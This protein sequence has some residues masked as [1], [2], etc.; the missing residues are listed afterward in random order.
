MEPRHD[1]F[2]QMMIANLKGA[3]EPE[4]FERDDGYINLGIGHQLYFAPFE[5]WS[6][7]ERQ[8]SDFVQGRVLDIGCGAGR[9]ALHFQA[10]GHD[11][12]ATD[13]S[14]LAIQ[15]CKERG[16]KDARIISVTKLSRQIG[17]F[18]TISLWGSF[19]MVGN[20]KRARW[21]LRRFRGMASGQGRIIAAARNP[22]K[23]DDPAHLA[24]QERN[25]Q[26][27]R[28]AGQ[29][30]LRVR[31]HQYAT[32][33]FDLLYVSPDELQ[34]I[35]DGTGWQIHQLLGGQESLYIAILEKED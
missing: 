21:L 34:D 31:F 27:G 16:V 23:T 28:M 13:I 15:V 12:V 26:R 5:T 24:Y 11:V 19:A 9:H 7:P 3:N 33:W 14:P 2:G 17:I 10:Q 30:R 8:A 35:L 6:A 32:P 25:R 29:V 20:P 22:Y 4:V 1:A 18:D